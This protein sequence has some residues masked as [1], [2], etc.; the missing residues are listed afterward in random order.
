VCLEE[1]GKMRLRDRKG[2]AYTISDVLSDDADGA[3]A[4]AC[5]RLK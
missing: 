3:L 5:V 1:G 4:A 2:G